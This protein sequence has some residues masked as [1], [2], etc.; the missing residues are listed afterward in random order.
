MANKKGL[1]TGLGALFGEDELTSP[2]NLPITKI[3]P[4][5][6]QPRT[7]FDDTALQELANSI[8]EHGLLQPITVRPLGTGY[9]QII[10]GERRWRASKLAGLKEVPVNVIEADDK[11]ASELA[12]VENLQRED[13]NPIEEA[14]GYRSLMQDYGMTQDAVSQSVGISRPAVAN[15]LRLLSL[16]DEVLKLTEDGKLSAGHARALLPLE[17][18]KVQLEVAQLVMSKMLSVRQTE[19]LVASMKKVKKPVPEPEPEELDYAEVAALDLG[20]ILGR[21]VS[22][23][24]KRNKGKIVLEYYNADDREKLIEQLKN[25]K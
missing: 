8:A 17:N 22:I 24:D 6:G 14:R 12:L 7:A 23:Q 20:K 19:Q 15:A 4:R 1:G 10:A 25:L 16:C 13:L 18:G 11:K 3:E 2:R 21:R 9:Y 5:I